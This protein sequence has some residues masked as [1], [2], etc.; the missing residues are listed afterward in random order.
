MTTDP[1]VTADPKEDDRALAIAARAGDSHAFE[2]LVLRYKAALYRLARRYVGETD[3]AYDIV[4][5]AF[6]AAWLALRRFDPSQSFIRWLRTILLN[7]CRDHA[8]RRAV[9]RRALSL[10]FLE[11]PQSHEPAELES[12]GEDEQLE[13]QR[14]RHLDRAIAELP[15]IYKDPLLLTMVAGLTQPEAARELNITVK[16]VEMR[17]RRAKLRLAETLGADPSVASGSPGGIRKS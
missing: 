3:E 5:E 15:P 6:V 14:L 2:E 10:F 1:N 9:R 7:R 4:Q 13:L 16:A 11:S 12:E 8:R 17:I